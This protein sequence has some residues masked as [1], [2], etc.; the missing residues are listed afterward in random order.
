MSRVYEAAARRSRSEGLREIAQRET[1]ALCTI[2][3]RRREDE[4]RGALT[5]LKH[6]LAGLASTCD[7]IVSAAADHPTAAVSELVEKIVEVAAADAR[8]AAQQIEARAQADGAEA[9]TLVARLQREIR[10]GQEQ[11]RAARAQL[12]EEHNAR[13]QAESAAERFHSVHPQAIAAL[14][15]QLR[16]I[17]AQ[18]GSNRAKVS[19]LAQQLAAGRAER[20]NLI[21]TLEA[22]AAGGTQGSLSLRAG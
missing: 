5:S 10:D 18:S 7:T 8:D 9:H 21:A 16:S 1:Y 11:L 4:W 14:H 22:V 3:L 20:A 12:Q 19:A 2:E 13:L 15:L 6:T 17:E